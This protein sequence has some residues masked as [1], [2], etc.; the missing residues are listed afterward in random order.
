MTPLILNCI[1]KQKANKH[2]KSNLFTSFADEDRIY[3]SLLIFKH[4]IGLLKAAALLGTLPLNVALPELLQEAIS[5][6]K[7]F[8]ERVCIL[9]I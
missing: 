8:E 5:P 6:W 7:T 3:R 2:R 9:A 4:F 1:L